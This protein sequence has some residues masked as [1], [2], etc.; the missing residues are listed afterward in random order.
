MRLV[1]MVTSVVALVTMSSHSLAA[2]KPPMSFGVTLGG[3]LSRFT[4]LDVSAADLLNGQSSM[5]NRTGLQAGGY[6]T[7]PLTT[8]VSLQPEVTYAQNG[9][10]FNVDGSSG[11]S[12]SFALNYASA[13]ALLRADLGGSQSWHPMVMAGPNLAARISCSGTLKSGGTSLSRDCK[14]LGSGSS[15]DPFE[16]KDIGAIGAVGLSGPLFHRTISLQARYARGFS[17]VT[18]DATSSQSPKNSAISFLVSLGY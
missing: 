13:A 12:L 18:K 9:A 8:H 4:E 2:Q 11:G 7:L 15:T 17:T 14:D 16:S 5:A 1:P 3:S 6:L 10:T